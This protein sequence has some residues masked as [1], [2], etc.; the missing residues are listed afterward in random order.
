MQS[1]WIRT[2]ETHG[3][4]CYANPD[5][6]KALFNAISTIETAAALSDG[7]YSFSFC[8]PEQD[9][10][11]GSKKTIQGAY[12][13]KDKNNLEGHVKN[14]DEQRHLTVVYA[15]ARSVQVE[16]AS[17]KEQADLPTFVRRG[18]NTRHLPTWMKEIYKRDFFGNEVFNAKLWGVAGT[19]LQKLESL[20]LY[21]VRAQQKAA[22]KRKSFKTNTTTHE[23]MAFA[24][25]PNN[26]CYWYSK[27]YDYGFEEPWDMV[28]LLIDNLTDEPAI[29]AQFLNFAV[30]NVIYML[31]TT[32]RDHLSQKLNDFFKE[33]LPMTYDEFWK[34]INEEQAI[35]GLQNKPTFKQILGFLQND[36]SFLYAILNEVIKDSKRSLSNVRDLFGVMNTLYL[37]IPNQRPFVNWSPTGKDNEIE[38]KDHNDKELAQKFPLSSLSHTYNNK[39]HATVLI[40]KKTTPQTL[41]D[42]VKATQREQ[43]TGITLTPGYISSWM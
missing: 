15:V 32:G 25:N 37:L 16:L 27:M 19:A 13:S 28:E 34:K 23:M 29:M 5:E 22:D 8:K 20:A 18:I 10:P 21:Q 38:L 1:P 35:P 3:D 43:E 4:N 17:P 14:E 42:W 7:H 6:E 41:I 11:Y 39:D 33:K 9:K 24:I 2:R 36:P 12:L 26:G 31:G 30:N 40:P